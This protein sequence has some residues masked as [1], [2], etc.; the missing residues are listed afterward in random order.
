MDKAELKRRTQR[1][2]ID[3]IKF[4]ESLP[5]K[6][7]LD[8]LSNQ[9]IRCATSIGAN[10]RSACRGK[11]TADFINKII[12]VE[13]EADESIYW[14]ELMEESELVNSI[15]I[16]ILKKEANELTAIF[17]AIGKTAREKQRLNKLEVKK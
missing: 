3:V 12:I 8:V 9:L 1:F 11:S 14:L 7:S 6:R 15:G 4:I 2:A 13:E 5:R 10:Y 17:T 16:T